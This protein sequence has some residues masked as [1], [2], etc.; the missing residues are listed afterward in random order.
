MSNNNS[1]HKPC[2]HF[3]L[4]RWLLAR[5]LSTERNKKIFPKRF[6][7]N[8]C[9]GDDVHDHRGFEREEAHESHELPRSPPDVQ[10]PGSAMRSSR[11][12]RRGHQA[13]QRRGHHLHLRKAGES[14]LSWSLQAVTLITHR[15]P[16][17]Y[18]SPEVLRNVRRPR[19]A[20]ARKAPSHLRAQTEVFA[21]SQDSSKGA[22][23]KPQ[24]HGCA[25]A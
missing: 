11:G 17:V 9:N 25:D 5:W 16:C 12:A 24:I 15:S 8:L 14:P 21:A 2:L 19:A 10:C 4:A 23:V 20:S 22:K 1:W 13:D 6:S 7:S 3:T 18:F